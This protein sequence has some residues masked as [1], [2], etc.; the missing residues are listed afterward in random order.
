M[1]CG[2]CT[3][4]IHRLL[5]QNTFAKTRGDRLVCTSEYTLR[6]PRKAREKAYIVSMSFVD[7]VWAGLALLFVAGSL[8][9]RH[10]DPRFIQSAQAR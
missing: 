2:C 10:P 6:R 7:A 9:G 5:R 8:K 3:L 4:V 1:M